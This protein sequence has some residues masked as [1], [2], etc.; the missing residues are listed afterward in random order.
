MLYGFFGGSAAILDGS[1]ECCLSSCYPI[2]FPH[3]A[4]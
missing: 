1:G 4:H 2:A 3:K